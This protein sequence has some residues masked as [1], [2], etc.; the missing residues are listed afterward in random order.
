MGLHWARLVVVGLAV[1]GFAGGGAISPAEE[2]S[3]P[4]EQSGAQIEAEQAKALLD[5]VTKYF[6]AESG[7]ERSKLAAEISRREGV[8]IDK[9]AEAIGN[10][11][12][13]DK[14]EEGE[15]KVS[16][17]ASRVGKGNTH[18]TDVHV[19]V[20]KG[21][22]AT[23]RYPLL[24]ALHGQGG[25]GESFMRF[26]A[27]LLGERVEEF[28][29]AAPTDYQGVWLGSREEV[30]G[31]TAVMLRM[32]RR[33][34][35]V[36]TDRVYC[37]GFSL[38]GHASC[39]LSLMH[40]EQFAAM[41]AVS[42]TFALQMGQE[43]VELMLPNMASVPLL[44]VY[45][46]L[47][48]PEGQEV[49]GKIGGGIADWNR[50][51]GGVAKERGLP[52]EVVEL[53]GC[54][55]DGIVPPPDRLMEY[56]SKRRLSVVKRVEHWFRYPAQGHATWLHQTRFWGDPWTAQQIV[57]S[58]AASE[59]VSEAVVALLTDR[60]AYLSGEIVGQT[61]RIGSR[62][63]S[64]VEVL[65][66]DALVDLDKEIEVF[67]DGTKR[68]EGKVARRIST[69]LELAY[70][71]WEFQRLWPVRLELSRKGRAVQG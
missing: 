66:S 16:F 44:L 33:R 45:G 8:T 31:D 49:G 6:R 4:S 30:V 26:T 60:L 47:D 25:D 61:I 39:L 50:W 9:V 13:W 51:V 7:R 58:P 67:L 65:L 37:F 38:G 1:V 3:A 24:L 71:D 36:D 54:G 53:A 46:E 42:G 19:R 5:S 35:H 48:K 52:I 59:S 21:Y 41:V 56:L 29:I 28:I 43:A 55:H 70:R 15:Q 27:K 64:K 17:T 68:Y 11:K 34:Y 10:V 22:D 69:M 2:P 18:T 32:L 20:P 12:L 23:K 14:Q 62:R 40:A 57:V 63:C